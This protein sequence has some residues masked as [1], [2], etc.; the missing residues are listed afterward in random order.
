MGPGG[1]DVPA[2]CAVDILGFRAVVRGPAQLI[3]QFRALHSAG[4][5]WTR[6]FTSPSERAF[7]IQCAASSSGRFQITRDGSIWA[8]TSRESQLLPW[9]DVAVN[10]AAVDSL[11]GHCLLFHA[12]VVASNGGGVILPA[13]SGSGKT[14][15]VAGLVNAGFQYFS[16][17][18]MVLDLATRMLLPFA[19]C[20]YVKRGARRLLATKFPTLLRDIP[21]L[22]FGRQTV[23]YLSPPATAWPSEPLPV[24]T[25]V[26]PRYVSHATTTLTEITPLRAIEHL[27][28]Q[29]FNLRELGERGMRALVSTLKGAE[30]YEL[31]VGNLDQAIEEITGICR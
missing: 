27:L 28:T 13:P 14:T 29:S 10:M 21:S 8:E 6:A 25:V 3:N 23:W 22:R 30:C 18:V 1:V 20:M 12:G 7:A 11:R 26:F 31:I 24:R 9:L 4:P 15:L 17:E 19:K 16:D 2:T 5:K